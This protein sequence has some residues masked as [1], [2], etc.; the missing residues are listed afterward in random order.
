MGLWSMGLECLKGTVWWSGDPVCL[1]IPGLTGLGGMAQQNKDPVCLYFWCCRPW[2]H[3]LAEQRS[4]RAVQALGHGRQSRD[5]AGLGEEWPDGYRKCL[6]IPSLKGS[7][8]GEPVVLRG[9]SLG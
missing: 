3:G 8:H 9:G 6:W 2:R 4:C 5:C 1:W 7:S